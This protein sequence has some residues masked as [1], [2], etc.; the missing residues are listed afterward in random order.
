M[1]I[2]IRTRYLPWGAIKTPMG[3][4]D[5][6]ELGSIGFLEC[7]NSLK[8]AKDHYPNEDFLEG[9]IMVVTSRGGTDES[10]HSLGP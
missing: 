5:G 4:I 3:R 9:K 10:H 7:F 2:Y 1:R 6:K 8:V